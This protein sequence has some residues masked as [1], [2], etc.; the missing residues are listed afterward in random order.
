MN[1]QLIG[2]TILNFLLLFS[3]SCDKNP[4]EKNSCNAIIIDDY[5]YFK[6]NQTLSN[7]CTEGDGVDYIVKAESVN[8]YYEVDAVLTLEQG[9]TVVFESGAGLAIRP[10][11]TLKSVGTASEQIVLRG[12]N[13]NAKGS[14][15]GV[16][17][18]SLNDNVL[19]YTTIKGGGGTSFNSNNDKANL[20]IYADTKVAIDNSTF[21]NSSAMG[22]SAN[23]YTNVTISSF[24]NNKFTANDVPLLVRGNTAN[25]VDASNEFDNNTNNYVKAIVGIEI[26]SNQIWQA[27][28]VPYR[29]FADGSFM[30][31]QIGNNGSLTI[32]K[33]AIVEFEAQTGLKVNTNGAFI[34]KGTSSEQITFRGASATAGYWD[35]IQFWFTQNPLNEIAYANI[36]HAGSDDGA[37]YMWADPKV[38]LSN[39][40]FSSITGCAVYDAPKGP[41]DATNPKLTRTNITY[42]NVGSQYC[43]GN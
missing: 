9:V 22:I 41:T 10:A 40:A 18:E 36:E 15:R 43:K 25:I 42:N 1:T 26:Q 39:T 16:Y 38:T 19:S 3:S 12:T 6:T 31:Q 24:S 11:G 27:L 2:I 13:E 5:S 7:H 8:G 33:G 14:W 35:G 4:D 20:V 29:L 23:Y 34:A 37:I 17:I 28:S 21:M 32:N 30:L